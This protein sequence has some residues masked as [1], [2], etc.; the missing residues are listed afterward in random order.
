VEVDNESCGTRENMRVRILIAE[1]LII[2]GEVV[3]WLS[4]G[5]VSLRVI[6]NSAALISGYYQ[7]TARSLPC[8]PRTLYRPALLPSP[9]G[10]FTMLPIVECVYMRAFHVRAKS[11]SSFSTASRPGCSIAGIS[12]RRVRARVCTQSEFRFLIRARRAQL[13]NG[14]PLR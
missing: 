2:S 10:P 8:P 13:R 4:R 5:G 14:V 7:E 9:P 12:I 1:K 6:G 3:T 11:T